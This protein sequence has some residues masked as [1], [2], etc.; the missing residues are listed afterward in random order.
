VRQPPE[1]SGWRRCAVSDDRG[2]ATLVVDAGRAPVPGE[3]AVVLEE[4]GRVSSA[5]AR[6]ALADL[7]VLP[8][9]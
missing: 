1:G 3:T 9:A 4:F 8:S 5:T 7:A 6:T 2:T